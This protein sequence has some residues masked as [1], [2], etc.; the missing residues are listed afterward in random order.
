MFHKI[1]FIL[2]RDNVQIINLLGNKS[3]NIKILSKNNN[4][5]QLIVKNDQKLLSL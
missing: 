2:K 3:S 1:I 4:C 5:Y